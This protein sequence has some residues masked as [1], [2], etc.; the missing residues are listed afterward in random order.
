MWIGTACR[1]TLCV[2]ILYL[3]QTTIDQTLLWRYLFI[4][5]RLRC[6]LVHKPSML[7]IL[8]SPMCYVWFLITMKKMQINFHFSQKI[9]F[10]HR[11]SHAS[12]WKSTTRTRTVRRV[13]HRPFDS[14]FYAGGCR[15]SLNSCCCCDVGFYSDW[16]CFDCSHVRD[17]FHHLANW[18]FLKI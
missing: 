13:F 17:I 1:P 4:N 7:F 18:I 8:L 15:F 9:Q 14:V 12:Q 2:C 10:N 6:K 5:D 3:S 16:M 11:T